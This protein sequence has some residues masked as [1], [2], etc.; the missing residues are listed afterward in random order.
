[1][2]KMK[3]DLLSHIRDTT[4]LSKAQMKNIMGDHSVLH[5]LQVPLYPRKFLQIKSC[6]WKLPNIGEVKINSDGSSR[7]NPGK[8]GVRFIIRDHTGTFLRTC[9]QGLGNVTSYMAECSALSQGL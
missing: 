4:H 5:K 9:S 6:F 1:M 7:G 3:R 2:P 8:W